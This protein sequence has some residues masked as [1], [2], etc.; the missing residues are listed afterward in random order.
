LVLREAAARRESAAE[1]DSATS[2]GTDNDLLKVSDRLDYMIRQITA[3]EFHWQDAHYDGHSRQGRE[4]LFLIANNEWIRATSEIVDIARSDAIETTIDIDVDLDR[5]THEAFHGRTGQIWLPIVVLPPLRQRLPDPE[6]FSTLMVTDASGSP[7]MTLPR[8]DVRHRIA[9]ALTEI[10]ITVAAARLPDLGSE[11][12]RVNV[13]RDHRLV[14]A[15]A[16]YRLLRGETVPEPVLRHEAH[17]RKSAQQSAGRVNSARAEVMSLLAPFSALLR[18]DAAGSAGE[19]ATRRL[20]E[21]AIRLLSAFTESAVVV[22]PVA[23][24]ESPTVLKVRLPGR[25]LH[26]TEARWKEAFGGEAPDWPW[27]RTQRRRR[28]YLPYWIFPSASLHLDVLLPSADA[29]RQ[30]RVNLPDGISPDPTRPLAMRAELDIRCEQPASIS[31]LAAVASHVLDTDPGWPPPLV[32][33]LADLAGSKADDAWACLRDHHIGAHPDEPPLEPQVAVI[34]TRTFRQ[35][36]NL[37]GLQLRE[38]AESGLSG[39]RREALAQAWHGGGWLREPMQRRTSTDTINPALVAARARMIEDASQRVPPTS[40]GLE[41]HIAVTDSAYFS[42]ARLSGGINLLLMAVELIFLPLARHLGFSVTRISAEVLALVLTL[43]T[44][45]QVGRIERPDRSTLR[46]LLVPS[47]NPL[48]VIS[49]VPP[50]VMAVAI[51]LSRSYIWVIAWAAGCILAQGAVLALISLVQRWGLRRGLRRHAH[52]RP[53]P[54]IVFYTDQPDYSYSSVV[55][56]SWWRRATAEAL[57]V[58]RPAYGYVVWQHQAPQ[59]FG[60]LLHGARPAS[61]PPATH[62]PS[63]RL[64]ELRHLRSGGNHLGVS[65]LEQPANVLALQRSGTWA[66]LLNFAV[67]R[68]KPKADWDS[69]EKDIV[70][71]EMDSGQLTLFED[72]ADTINVFLGIEPGRQISVSEHPVTLVLCLAALRGLVVRETQLPIP[73]PIA[74]YASLQWARI[75]I[76]TFRYDLERSVQFLADLQHMTTAAVVALETHSGGVLRVLNPHPTASADIAVV[77]QATHAGLV[78]ASDLDVVARSQLDQHETADAANWRVMALCEDWYMGVE[79]LL[80]T[81]LD[82]D[83]TL[84]GLTSGVL[85]GKSVLLLL[86]H[87]PDG[88]RVHQPDRPERDRARPVPAPCF[89]R[90]LSRPTLGSA[91]RHPLL[92]VHM[93]APDRPGATLAIL[94]SLREALYDLSPDLPEWRDW[95]VWYAKA[96]VE[97]GNVA[98]VQLTVTLPVP[99]DVG[100]ADGP[101][102]L[103]NPGGFA[104]I[105]RQ[106]MALLARKANEDRVNGESADPAADIQSGTIVRIGFVTAPTL[107]EP[108]GTSP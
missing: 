1:A 28:F 40:A 59:T 6:P 46:G 26:S 88:A 94:E 68:D 62:A 47:G 57:L 44:A 34:K 23:R 100:S 74:D 101:L 75:R 42:T 77:N 81:R 11:S 82:P 71:I 39:D 93:R 106:T 16:V 15:A 14:L 33:G 58:G 87:R 53:K 5:I 17:A 60:S 86:C 91:P 52:I 30:I 79:G 21:R 55:H 98:H 35:R 84:L 51:A 76:S 18:D 102:E 85:H 92:R 56:S 27:A 19:S 50:V 38:V 66:Q 83:L 72:T 105:E 36:L 41:V 3:G 104:K 7:L 99:T 61:D 97:N 80:L 22:V 43:F 25:A 8:T 12:Q 24:E 69:A 45:I 103:L 78:L 48:I 37:L 63:H 73:P 31:H 54:I 90:W 64:S 95:H 4:L 49:I 10:I 2:A 65:P 29:D 89:D 9:A 67:F 108:S 13:S 20:A 107:S 32:Q 70:T 96:I